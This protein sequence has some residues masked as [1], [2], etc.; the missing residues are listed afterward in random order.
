MYSAAERASRRCEEA[1]VSTSTPVERLSAKNAP[2]TVEFTVTI[3]LSNSCGQLA[4]PASESLTRAEKPQAVPSVQE[5]GFTNI[6]P[7]GDN[8]ATVG[9]SFTDST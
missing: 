2:G 5:I 8:I 9:G 3:S 1:L 6:S 4:S 7:A